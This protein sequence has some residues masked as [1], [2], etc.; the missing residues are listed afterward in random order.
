MNGQ[1]LYEKA[2]AVHRAFQMFSEETTDETNGLWAQVNFTTNEWNSYR[3]CLYGAYGN[4]PGIVFPLSMQFD[5]SFVAKQEKERCMR[6]FAK[7]WDEHAAPGSKISFF[8]A[9]ITHRING[10]YAVVS[11]QEN[12]KAF[13]YEMVAGDDQ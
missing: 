3:A 6:S 11:V 9:R 8:P 10:G 4:S 2:V 1:K 13:E 12:E 5:K 7:F